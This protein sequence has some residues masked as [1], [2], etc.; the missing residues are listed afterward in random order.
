MIYLVIP[1]WHESARLPG[2]LPGLCEALLQSGL[3]VTVRVVDDGSGEEEASRLSALLEPLRER[4]PFLLPPLLLPV[5]QGKGGAVLAGWDAV[6]AEADWVAFVDADGAVP[7]G[8]VVR[9]CRMV[10]GVPR[11]PATALFAV[12][13][14]GAGYMVK[15]TL[16][17]RISGQVF[18]QIVRFLFDL[19]VPDT[20][21]GLKIIPHAA[22]RQ[23]RREMQERRWCFD[24][25]LTCLLLRNKVTLLPVPIDWSESP[26]S[27]IRPGT[28]FEMAASL[29]RLRRRLSWP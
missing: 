28:A 29:V 8:E 23:V 12:R 5:N 24:V 14:S 22:A 27:K 2:F 20:Q 16:G 21:C 17:R 4:F 25:E 15:R 11:E 1:A 19:P 7:A 3:P 6:P 18:R 10:G 26:G 9:L 13:V